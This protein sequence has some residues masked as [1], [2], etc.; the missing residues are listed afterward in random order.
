MKTQVTLAGVTFTVSTY[1]ISVS[2]RIPNV[3]E[4]WF[5]QKYLEEHYYDPFIKSRY[6]NERKR[7]FPFSYLLE[8]MLP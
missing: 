7:I 1:I 3:G 5:K 6:K 4:K 2:T 8:D